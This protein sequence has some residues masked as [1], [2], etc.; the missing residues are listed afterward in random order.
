MLDLKPDKLLKK[1]SER[2]SKSSGSNKRGTVNETE[3]HGFIRCRM[4]GSSKT[5]RS[6]IENK[7][8]ITKVRRRIPRFTYAEK[9]RVGAPKRKFEARS[10]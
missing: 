3:T 10:S 4:S 6:S 2:W 1:D 9:I 5:S 7:Y 8:D